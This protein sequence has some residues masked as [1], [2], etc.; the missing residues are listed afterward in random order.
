MWYSDHGKGVWNGGRPQ[1]RELSITKQCRLV[2]IAR[3]SFYYEGRGESPLNLRL[4]PD[5]FATGA[6]TPKQLAAN[7]AADN[8]AGV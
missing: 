4:M 5:P 7:A 1:R 3:S 8:R 6:S 2:S